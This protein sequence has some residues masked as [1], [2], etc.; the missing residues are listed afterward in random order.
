MP[1]VIKHPKYNESSSKEFINLPIANTCHTGG[2]FFR[3]YHPYKGYSKDFIC[4]KGFTQ[5]DAEELS[6]NKE[7]CGMC[8]KNKK[9]EELSVICLRGCD[10]MDRQIIPAIDGWY[11]SEYQYEFPTR[12]MILDSEH[13]PMT[14]EEVLEMKVGDIVIVCQS[15]NHEE[16]GDH[17]VVKSKLLP[18]A[19]CSMEDIEFTYPAFADPEGSIYRSLKR[20]NHVMFCGDM[21]AKLAFKMQERSIFPYSDMFWSHVCVTSTVGEFTRYLDASLWE[22]YSDHDLFHVPYALH[23]VVGFVKL[24]KGCVGW[25]GA[26][27]GVYVSKD[28]PKS[29]FKATTSKFEDIT[30]VT[31]K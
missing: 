14:F 9:P 8:G 5:K 28:T 31:H 17:Y 18:E 21:P 26:L 11:S 13:M 19:E 7:F 27:G 3:I 15:V 20:R 23:D 16:S 10:C 22:R 1:K 29:V 6:W 24:C 25:R 12:C 4:A 30:I 2:R